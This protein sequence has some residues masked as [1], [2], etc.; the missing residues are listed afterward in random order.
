MTIDVK[1]SIGRWQDNLIY[2]N[3]TKACTWFQKALINLKMT[4]AGFTGVE[5]PIPPVCKIYGL[6]II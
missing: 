1:D 3:G 4:N 2:M 5:C 6:R